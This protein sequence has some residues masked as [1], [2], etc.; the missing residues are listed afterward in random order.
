MADDGGL[1]EFFRDGDVVAK[2]LGVAEL[3]AHVADV[4]FVKKL[5]T[6]QVRARAA[7]SPEAIS[8]LARELMHDPRLAQCAMLGAGVKLQ[9]DEED[10]KKAERLGDIEK[11]SPLRTDD[12][13]QAR[14]LATADEAKAA[15]L[16]AFESGDYARALAL[17]CRAIGVDREAGRPDNYELCGTLYGNVAQAL[18][19]LEHFFRAEQA[20]TR[21]LAYFEAIDDAF[22]DVAGKVRKATYR[23][24]LARERLKKYKEALEDA[25]RASDAKLVARLEKLVAHDAKQRVSKQR[26]VDEERSVE[27][28]RTSGVELGTSGKD[29]VLGYLE[30]RDFSHVL[31]SHMDVSQVRIDLANK[32]YIRLERLL[33]DASK[34]H[35]S[36]SSKR[37]RKAL[38]YDLDLVCA[39]Q[40][41]ADHKT[42]K[43]TVRLYNISH[44]TRFEPG[45]DPAV[46]YMYQ[47]GYQALQAAWFDGTK[48]T[49]QAPEWARLLIDG[50]HDLYDAL[51]AH[52]DDRLREFKARLTTTAE[53]GAPP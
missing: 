4:G 44:E 9:V 23:R 48:A 13:L 17:W 35:A 15:G 22:V 29:N 19:K 26:R 51:A 53:S 11:R 8:E 2:C 5:Q 7:K 33:E 34:I 47:I 32:A 36:V 43:G 16:A 21:A 46:A 28:R 24:A 42:I 31:Q 38:Y 20:A 10:M 27:N 52:V 49:D 39:W 41:T 37:G 45:A 50:A 6:M 25:L 40:G 18:L 30:E 12:I 1:L 3:R 14:K